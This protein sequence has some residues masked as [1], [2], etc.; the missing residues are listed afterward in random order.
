MHQILVQLHDDHRSIRRLLE[1]LSIDPGVT[2]DRHYLQR[3]A[4]VM[5][6]MTGY[7]DQFHH[8]RE[9]LMFAPLSERDAA[10]CDVIGRLKEEHVL[11]GQESLA[12]REVFYEHLAADRLPGAELRAQT[13]GYI[14]LQE[15]HM[16]REELAVFAKARLVLT[17]DDWS[18]IDT[19][20]AARPDPVFG[21]QVQRGFRELREFLMGSGRG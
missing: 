10:S 13:R 2:P 5:R 6:Y 20:L 21:R 18:A 12:L 3:G 7:P 11:L 19:L 1:L 4:D 14:E 8:P 17:A 9:D 16:E 15:G